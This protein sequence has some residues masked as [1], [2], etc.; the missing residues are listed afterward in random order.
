MRLTIF[1][2]LN[3]YVYFLFQKNKFLVV[4][5]TVRGREGR[6]VVVVRG[7]RSRLLSIESR[8]GSSGYIMFGVLPGTL[9]HNS[10]L[11]IHLFNINR[12]RVPDF[13]R[14]VK[15][16]GAHLSMLTND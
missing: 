6:L 5:T 9:R 11:S 10:I 16:I 4:G 13:A 2:N 12:T 15:V 8:L 1:L 7:R 14:L 3:F